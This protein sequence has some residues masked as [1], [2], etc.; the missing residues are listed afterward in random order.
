MI[1][2][3]KEY[4][5]LADKPVIYFEGEILKFKT[6]SFSTDLDNISSFKFDN[7]DRELVT[8]LNSLKADN[9][10][11]VAFKDGKAIQIHG[12]SVADVHVYSVDG[13]SVNAEI[14]NHQGGITINFSSLPVGIYIVKV[15]NQSYKINNK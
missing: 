9:H 3:T 2:G 13:R 12:V 7:V 6:D 8:S 15:N 5:F 11:A 10:I 14:N 4:F 1:D